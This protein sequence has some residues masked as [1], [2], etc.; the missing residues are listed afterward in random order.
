MGSFYA[1]CSVTRHT[2]SDGQEMYIQFMLPVRGYRD[3]VSIGEMFKDGFLDVVK[4]KGLEEAIKSFEEYTSTWGEGNELSPKGL[5]VSNDGPYVKW[6]P[7]GPAIRG[8][9]ADYGNI[10]PSEDEDSQRRVKILE[11]LMGDLPFSTILDVAQDS[12][13]Y[14]L[15]LGKYKDEEGPNNWRPEGI[16]KDMPEWLLLL[17][18]KISLTY[19]HASV[20]DTL[21]QNDFSSEEKEG[22]MKSKYDIQWKNEYL[23][24]IKKEFPQ[25]LDYIKNIANSDGLEDLI[26]KMEKK[27]K[28]REVLQRIGVFRNLPE[29]LSIIYQARM[30]KVGGDLGWFYENLNLMYSLSGMCV[31]LDQSEYGSQH[32][33]FFGW[34]RIYNALQPKLEETLI[35]YGYYDCEDEGEDES[36]DGE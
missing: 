26:E 10:E 33:N 24:P 17:C 34:R 7:F 3:D 28:Q 27:W 13:W 29:D 12:R 21:C 22:I 31:I 4:V 15:G 2:I 19:F 1:T 16:H 6:V 36:D 14:T 9:Y 35:S 30:A 32:I 8:H 11:E 25:V 20:Y 5:N 18:Q 23:G